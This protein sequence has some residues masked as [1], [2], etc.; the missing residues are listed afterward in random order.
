[1][2][3]V[4][5]GNGN[6]G[7]SLA[8]L[9]KASG[10]AVQVFDSKGDSIEA[11]R[12]AELVVLAI[13]Y[14]Q[15]LELAGR[16]DISSAVAGKIVVDVTNP[17]TPDY[18]ALTVGHSS[19]AAEQIASRIPH[20]RVVKAF[21]TIFAA[22]LAKRAAGDPV[23]V[24]VFV[25]GDDTEAVETVA[26]MGQAMGFETIFAGGLV[27]ARYLEPLAELMIQFGYGLGHGDRIGFA[28]MRES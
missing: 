27:N 14:P 5:L 15:A 4:V 7:A 21:N 11:L 9:A 28:L 26:A 10:H 8:V 20:A 2:N 18:M 23:T 13:G 24:P 3:I 1:M 25:A 12:R 6:M 16:P 22:I 19:S 17:L